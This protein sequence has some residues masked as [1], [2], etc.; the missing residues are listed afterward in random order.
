IGSGTLDVTGLGISQA[1]AIT[2]A[3]SA[4]TTTFNAG[5]G[6]INL[7][8]AGNNLTGEVSLNN[9]GNNNVTLVNTGTLLSLGASTLGSGVTSIT[10]T[11]ALTTN[12]LISSNGNVSL[13][14]LSPDSSERVLTI[15]SGGIVTSNGAL[16]SLNAANNSTGT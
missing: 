7:N 14:T 10:N 2:Q 15:N 8:N 4:G 9:S 13:T 12:G 16:I 1:G 3:A 6:V 11:G 5:A